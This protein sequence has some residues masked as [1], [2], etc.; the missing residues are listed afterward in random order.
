VAAV[1]RNS[2]AQIAP[3]LNHIVP[4]ILQA[5]EKSDDEL[6]E[7]ALQALETLVLRC[8]TDI[9]IYLPTI[10]EIGNK[11]IKYDPVC[12]TICINL[13]FWWRS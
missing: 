12:L 2:P 9:D 5:A 1:A 7:G 3:V 10:V 13:Y 11:F 4:G 6:R 8:P